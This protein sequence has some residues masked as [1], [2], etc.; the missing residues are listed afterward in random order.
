MGI[1][2]GIVLLAVGL[3]LAL[4]VGD[5]LEAVDLG[6]IGWILAGVGALAVVVALI[7]NAQRSHR[8]IEHVNRDETGAAAGSGAAG[9]GGSGARSGH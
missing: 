1:G 9:G 5:P 7:M 3:V 4:A 6:L 2:I 8:T